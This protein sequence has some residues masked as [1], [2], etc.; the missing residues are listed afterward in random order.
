M[1]GAQIGSGGSGY[2]SITN[3]AMSQV[4]LY[5]FVLTATEVSNHFA[6]ASGLPAL[7]PFNI[8]SWSVV[9]ENNGYCCC[10]LFNS[11]SSWERVHEIRRFPEPSTPARPVCLASNRNAETHSRTYQPLLAGGPTSGKAKSGLWMCRM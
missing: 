3:C 5:N 9:D 1:I 4:A 8:T 2:T 10:N 11:S 7:S 6:A